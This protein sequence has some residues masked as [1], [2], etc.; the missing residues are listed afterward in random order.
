MK[1]RAYNFR[2]TNL[3]KGIDPRIGHQKP[4]SAQKAPPK[5]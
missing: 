5:G 2:K 4:K 3:E 1:K